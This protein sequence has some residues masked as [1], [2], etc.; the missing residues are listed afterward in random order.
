MGNE[1]SADCYTRHPHNKVVSEWIT[2]HGYVPTGPNIH[3]AM[4]LLMKYR[5]DTLQRS[6]L[7]MPTPRA[8]VT[9]LTASPLAAALPFVRCGSYAAT[10]AGQAQLKR[11]N[12]IQLR[13]YRHRHPAHSS[14]PLRSALLC[15]I[16]HACGS[17][18]LSLSRSLAVSLR[19]VWQC[20]TVRVTPKGAVHCHR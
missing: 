1:N 6:P 12:Y 2:S 3:L 19:P 16:R 17:L 18:P 9:E 5:H 7:P 20:P 13:T 10:A 15:C 4:R 8:L 14:A 11:L